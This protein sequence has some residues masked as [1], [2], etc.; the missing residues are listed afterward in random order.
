MEDARNQSDTPL[1]KVVQQGRELVIVTRTLPAKS[2]G[3]AHR[4]LLVSRMC[5]GKGPSSTRRG[6]K[7]PQQQ[8]PRGA[9]RGAQAEPRSMFAHDRAKVQ[10]RKSTRLNSSHEWISRMPSSA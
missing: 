10:D 2:H 6:P 9:D 8:V 5:G 3:D 1:G 7:F 4:S